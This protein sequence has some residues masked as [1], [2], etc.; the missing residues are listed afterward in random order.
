MAYR[1]LLT[2]PGGFQA[3]AIDAWQAGSGAEVWLLVHAD[4]ATTAT[5]IGSLSG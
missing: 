4:P 5:V 2:R 1:H 3:V